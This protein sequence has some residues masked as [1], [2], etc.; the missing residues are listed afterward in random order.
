[1]AAIA[2]QAH[3]KRSRSGRREAVFAMFVAEQRQT[4]WSGSVHAGC[5]PAN[6]SLS[7]PLVSESGRLSSAVEWNSESSPSG[8]I[9]RCLPT[10]KLVVPQTW[11]TRDVSG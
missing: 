5:L 11:S 10:G 4:I 8:V 1:M 9:A 7:L 2:A 3:L 6:V